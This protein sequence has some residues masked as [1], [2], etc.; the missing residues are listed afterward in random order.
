MKS[1]FTNSTRLFTFFLLSFLSIP[2]V[3]LAQIGPGI[4]SVNSPSGGFNVDGT[5]IANSTTGDWVDGTGSGGFILTNSGAPLNVGT[6]YHL[7]DPYNISSDN[8]F[9][10]GLKVTDNPNDWT[11]VTGTANDKTDMNNALIHLTTDTNGNVWVIFAADRLSNSGNAY[12]DFEFL[13]TTMTKTAG[14]FA[15]SAPASTGGRSEG[16]FLLTVYFESGVAKF[17]I[18]RWEL[19]GSVWDYKTYFSALPLNSVFAAGNST[20]VPVPFQAFGVNSYLQ[21]TFIESAVNLTAVLGAID[22]CT[23]LK[24]KTVF[25]KSKT[26]TSSSAA[27]KDFFD[28]LAID[29]LTLGSAD[30]GDD[31]TVCTGSSYML[32]GS[33][34]PSN[35]YQVISKNWSVV[36]GSATITD[37]ENLNSNISINGSSATFRLTVVTGPIAGSGSQCTVFDDVIITVNQPLTCSINGSVDPICPSSFSNIY[38]APNSATYLW[39]ISGNGSIDGSTNSQTV[40]VTAGSV[41]NETFILSLTITDE[42]GCTSTCTKTVTVIDNTVPIINTSAGSLNHTLQCNNT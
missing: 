18:Q 41:C 25:V 32:Q 26:S 4:A 15:T 17:D 2:L 35:G 30:A 28:P 20:T 6:T 22:P 37:P 42:N 11:W 7:F 10:G 27:I 38:S 36:S 19:N 5:L 16:D 23:S 33:A 14:G 31:D 3:I 40:S 21:N 9:G 29:N 39:N 8:I 24:I 13:Q 12:V 1:T 34:I